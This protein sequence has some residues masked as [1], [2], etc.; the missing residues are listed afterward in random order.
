MRSGQLA[1][2]GAETPLGVLLAG[3]M[4]LVAGGVIALTRRRGAVSER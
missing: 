3:A 1:V 4:L 2:T